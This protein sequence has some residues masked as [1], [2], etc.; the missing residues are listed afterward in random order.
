MTTLAG[1]VD[2]VVAALPA[3]YPY[4]YGP[5][6]TH[7]PAGPCYIIEPPAVAEV[8]G[9]GPTC[10]VTAATVDIV[11]VPQ[12]ATDYSMLTAMADAVIAAFGGRISSGQAEPNP[13]ADTDDAYSYRLTV[14][15]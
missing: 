3:D 13:Y 8:L 11:C 12:T 4:V 6:F 15:V 10:R 2:T 14:E 1:I 5:P 9:S 7:P